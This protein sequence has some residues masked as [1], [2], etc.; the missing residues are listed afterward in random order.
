MRLDGSLVR[1]KD[2]VFLGRVDG[3][4]IGLYDIY[5]YANTM[6]VAAKHKISWN[7]EDLDI[8]AIHVGY[9][10][11]DKQAYYITRPPFRKQKQ[12]TAV[13]NVYAA[14]AGTLKFG[15]V[16]NSLFFSQ[17]LK[18]AVHLVYPPY[19]EAVKK[20]VKDQ[21]LKSIAFSPEFALN[22][23]DETGV[24][25]YCDQTRVGQ[26]D[27]NDYMQLDADCQDSILVQKLSDLGVPVA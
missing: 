17:G 14:P 1:Y 26:L 22:T 19:K 6:G 9:I 13:S 18:D 7:D 5:E 2:K 12:G 24:V 20:V 3:S 16:A 27:P 10:N 8:R 4:Y 15:P 11:Y 23:K 21:N 25:L